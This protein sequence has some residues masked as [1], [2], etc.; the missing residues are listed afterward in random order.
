MSHIVTYDV[1][2]DPERLDVLRR[3]CERL[4]WQFHQNQQTYCWFGQWVGNSPIPE[5]LLTADELAMINRLSLPARKEW[6]NNKL[7]R[8]QHCI[9]VPG[10]DYDIAL[11]PNPT[12][13]KLIAY[14][15]DWYSGGLTEKLAALELSFPQVYSSELLKD[16]LAAQ[17]YDYLEIYHPQTKTLEYEVSR[18]W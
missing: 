12:T 5:K 3:T 11:M 1:E 15:D 2:I 16:Q 18:A 8:C 9:S 13:G 7:A 4:G 10:C 6:M 17:G 14:F